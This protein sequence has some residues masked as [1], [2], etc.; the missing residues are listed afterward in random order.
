MTGAGCQ[1]ERGA[2][3]LPAMDLAAALVRLGGDGK[4]LDDLIGFFFEDAF[5]LL[6]EM[7]GSVAQRLAD[8]AA[9][10]TA[11]R[12]WRQTSVPR[13][14]WRHCS[15]WKPTTTG[16]PLKWRP[17]CGTSTAR[18]RDWRPPWPN[19]QRPNDLPAEIRRLPGPLHHPARRPQF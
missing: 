6:A 14:R 8:R 3:E 2:G 12:D 10:R 4:L 9:R 19:S 13:R 18:Y 16:R 11:S 17:L 1:T 15:W 7:H 5:K